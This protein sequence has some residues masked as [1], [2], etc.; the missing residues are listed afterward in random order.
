LISASLVLT[1]LVGTLVVA[2]KSG[3]TVSFIDL[4]TGRE[5]A[6]IEVG[7]A[8]HELAVS[9]DGRTVLVGE[10]GPE[11]AHGRTVAIL[12]LASA[13][14]VGR[15]DVGPDSRPHSIAFLPGGSRAVVT[16]QNQDTLAILDLESRTVARTIPTGGRESH[17][18]RLSPDARRA[19]VTSRL[20]EGTLSIIDL[21]GDSKTRVLE[22]GAGAEGL[23]VTP[24]GREVWVLDREAGTIS[25]VDTARSVVAE[26]IPSRMQSNRIAIS[27]AGEAVVTNGTSGE[28]VVQYVNLLDVETRTKKG[29]EL[30]LRGGEPGEGAFGIWIQDRTAFIADTNGGRVLA[31]DLDAWGDEPRVLISGL[32]KERPDGMGWSPVRV[33]AEGPTPR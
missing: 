10:Y 6:R 33:E 15:I 13:T 12:D 16:L 31:Y 7:R 20:G 2:N 19:Y 29:K 27:A 24:D 26:R 18:V 21:E 23:A 25:V 30:P 1:T 22:T 28:A 32:E 11:D 17:M 4:D 9:P 3:D 5:A 8:P 14:V